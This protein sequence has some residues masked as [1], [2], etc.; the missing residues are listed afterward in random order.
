[1][2]LLHWITRWQS[3]IYSGSFSPFWYCSELNEAKRNF[4]VVMHRIKADR[5]EITWFIY[6]TEESIWKQCWIR[7]SVQN[8]CIFVSASL[9]CCVE[10]FFM[11]SCVLY[12]VK[13]SLSVVALK[14]FPD[15]LRIHDC[16]ISVFFK[17]HNVSYVLKIICAVVPTDRGI[18]SALIT[19][20]LLK[21][22][23]QDLLLAR[24]LPH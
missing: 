24:N 22:Q 6:L 4:G 16:I 12:S 20:I 11:N 9:Q 10:F 2:S 5:K 8:R 17:A 7:S 3:L 15:L 1:M 18:E 23:W 21:W 14:E 19:I 13:D